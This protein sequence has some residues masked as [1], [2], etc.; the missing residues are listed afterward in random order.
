MLRPVLVVPALQ[1]KQTRA[2]SPTPSTSSTLSMS[3]RQKVAHFNEQAEQ[4]RRELELTVSPALGGL[5]RS[6][7]MA[8]R[9]SLALSPV[10]GTPGELGRATS[11]KAPL[12]KRMSVAQE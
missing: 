2:V 12:L 8:S 11:F 7:S 10:P 1:Q 9:R 4:A 3:V 6:S 5:S